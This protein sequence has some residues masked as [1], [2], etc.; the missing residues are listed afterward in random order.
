MIFF[1]KISVLVVMDEHKTGLNGAIR[2]SCHRRRK[3][4][5]VSSE[6][7]CSSLCDEYQKL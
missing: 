4:L 6:Q 1:S 5:E 3:L 2:W 7:H